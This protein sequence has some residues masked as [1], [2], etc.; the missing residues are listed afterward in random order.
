MPGTFR[1]C[2]VS[3][4]ARGPWHIPQDALGTLLYSLMHM[5]LMSVTLTAYMALGIG[6]HLSLAFYATNTSLVSV[7]GQS[8]YRANS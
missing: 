1:R 8:L 2:L 5:V 7:A 4:T 6:D 3:Y